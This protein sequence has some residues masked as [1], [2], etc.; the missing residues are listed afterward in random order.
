M[1]KPAP[2]VAMQGSRASWQQ[3]PLEDESSAPEL[4]HVQPV[5]RS[6][7]ELDLADGAD[8]ERSEVLGPRHR[9]K[10][11]WTELDLNDE[12][13]AP[14]AAR[15]QLGPNIEPAPAPQ[16]DWRQRHLQRRSV[17]DGGLHVSR[18]WRQL[19]LQE[20]EVTD[21]E[22]SAGRERERSQHISDHHGLHGQL[23]DQ[24]T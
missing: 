2:A 13:I 23:A 9:S 21:V 20:D 5:V 19:H 1:L 22:Q 12:D 14:L 7:C 11:A 24:E 15:R 8:G 4:P 16:R 6:W 10:R 18:D 17:I 3:C